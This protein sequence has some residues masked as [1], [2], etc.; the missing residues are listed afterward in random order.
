VL[1][2]VTL[3]PGDEEAGGSAMTAKAAAL[4][5]VGTGEAESPRR[6]GDEWEVDVE[7]PN[8]SLVEV[9]I[10]DELE[11]RGLDEELGAHG[12][13]AVDE[14]TGTAREWAT[15]TASAAAGRGRALSA[16][17]ESAD[18]VE[19][20]LRRPSG[21]VVEVELESGRVVEIEPEHPDDE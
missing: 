11:L 19:V 14:L 13:R 18:V 20:N 17:R 4:H 9:T 6:D 8:G 1:T 2:L 5:W 10:G 3:Q 21:T 12:R 16:E 15:R 7:R